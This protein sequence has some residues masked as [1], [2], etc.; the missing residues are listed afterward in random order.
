MSFG[1]SIGDFITLIQLA[2]RV[3]RDSRKACGAH[4]ELTHEVSSLHTV[5]QRFKKETE[6]AKSP[7]NRPGDS[8][9]DELQSIL[10]GCKKLLETL[11]TV[12]IKYNSLSQEK[13]SG[14]RLWQ[15]IRFGNGEMQDLTELRARLVYYTSALSLFLNMVSIGSVGRVERR[16]E[17]AGGDLREIK[18][19]VN[20]I[21]AHLLGGS[22][23]EGSILTAYADDDKAVWKEFRRELVSEG[24][25]SVTIR[26]HKN[27]I[28]AYV[29][30]L[31]SRGLLDERD[32]YGEDNKE[33]YNSSDAG[34]DSLPTPSY[35]TVQADGAGGECPTSSPNKFS[36]HKSSSDSEASLYEPDYPS[37]T[38]IDLT[39][40]INYTPEVQGDHFWTMGDIPMLRLPRNDSCKVS[41]AGHTIED[42]PRPILTSPVRNELTRCFRCLSDILIVKIVVLRCGHRMCLAC[43][44][45]LFEL[46]IVEPH[47]MPPRCCTED[48]IPFENVDKIF[49]EQF[50]VQWVQ[51]YEGYLEKVNS[52]MMST[53]SF[54][55]I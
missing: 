29:R 19:A 25:S 12:M 42:V 39:P 1:F 11:E 17:E 38:D 51:E 15:R 55:C 14:R 24:F 48:H 45:Q 47:Y 8:C 33:I 22:K 7:L 50:Q 18:L 30:E 10:A 34:E 3:V 41:R 21:T 5:L 31:A 52:P 46:S 28:K 9:Q 40:S 36:Y 27:T 26:K 16:M 53:S 6:K 23:P 4:D 20:G 37:K 43:L 44:R 32:T 13:R 35:G 49:N 2:S 54:L